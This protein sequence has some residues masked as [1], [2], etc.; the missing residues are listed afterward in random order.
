MRPASCKRMG[1]V[2]PRI[3]PSFLRSFLD[4]FGF[5]YDFKSSTECYAS[6][7]FDE[8]LLAVLAHYDEIM[9]VMLPTL[10]AERRASFSPILPISPK[11]GRVLQVPLIAHDADAGTVT[12]E[13]ED[14]SQTEVPATGGHCKLGWKTDWAMRWVALEVDYEMSPTA[15]GFCG[16]I[17][18]DMIRH[19]ISRPRR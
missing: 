17:L 2:R 14:G 11:T 16:D 4:R 7:L 18:A 15:I 3:R 19:R 9:A 10:R 5:D 12:F 6:G 13:D 8:T 1:R